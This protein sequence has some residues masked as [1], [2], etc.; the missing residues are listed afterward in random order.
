MG[1]A[2]QRDAVS[3]RAGPGQTE[4]EFPAHGK[5]ELAMRFCRALASNSLATVRQV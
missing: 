5:P 1:G 3:R 4:I 2:R